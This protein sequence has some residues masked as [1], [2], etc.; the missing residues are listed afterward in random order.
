MKH[1]AEDLGFEHL[2][3]SNKEDFL[4]NKD[5]FF[6]PK[7][8]EKAILFEIF[9]N[10]QDES[11]A[12]KIMNTLETSPRGG[13]KKQLKACLAIRGTWAVKKNLGSLRGNKMKILILAGTGAMGSTSG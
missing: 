13:Q 9:T 2:T 5:Y 6:T 8:L 7:R 11:D 1:Y 3:A 4:L 12:L 10:S